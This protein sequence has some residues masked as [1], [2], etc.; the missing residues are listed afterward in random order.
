MDIRADVAQAMQ[1]ILTDEAARTARAAGLSRRASKRGG[2]TFAQI[3][4]F[5]GLKRPEP[6]LED[7]AQTAA[8][9]GAPVQPQAIDQRF[10]PQAADCLQR[11]LGHA[12]R[13]VV[14]Q[15]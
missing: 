11:V 10:T 6:T 13:Q 4:T 1:T 5:G 8:A 7:F 14:A 9:C 15:Q 3:M 12:I 2:A